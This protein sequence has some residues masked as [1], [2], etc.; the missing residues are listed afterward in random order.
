MEKFDLQSLLRP[1]LRGLKPYSSARDEYTGSEGI[2]LDANENSLGS[3]T[4]D[5]YN[6]YP[7]PYQKVLKEKLG[8]IKQVSPANIFF[9]NG[10]DEPIDLLY[11]AFCEPGTDNVILLP[12]TYGM[13]EVSANIHNI[14]IK[15]VN[16]T[17]DY[18]I[19]VVAVKASIDARTKIIWICS[20]NNPTGNLVSDEAI[21]ELLGSFGGLVVV[22][23]AYIDFANKSS[24]AQR[25]DQYPNLVVLQT[26]S[27]AWGMAGI[28]LGIAY[29]SEAIISILN[30]IKSPYNISQLT[31]S[32]ALEA[33][34][35]RAKVG[36]MVTEIVAMRNQM[37]RDMAQLPNVLKVHP[38]DANFILVKFTNANEIFEYLLDRKIIIR[39]RSS[40]VLCEGSLRITIGTS[41]ENEALLSALNDFLSK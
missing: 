7:D 24:W 38:S 36:N 40:V 31:Q 14:S 28:R 23:E 19:D 11:R 30:K 37:A 35:N 20:P 2:F 5:N 41:S 1:H 10:S 3:A 33:L 26:F 34:K 39:N 18:Q 27:K 21:H 9:G 4:S 6:R 15:K 25:L 17:P 12:P 22:D 32:V 29:T 8:S 16:L 13:Y